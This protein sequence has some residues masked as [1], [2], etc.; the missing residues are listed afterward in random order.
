MLVVGEWSTAVH[1]LQIRSIQGYDIISCHITIVSLI[2][3]EGNHKVDM[4]YSRTVTLT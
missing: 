2:S 4:M 1:V 3:K